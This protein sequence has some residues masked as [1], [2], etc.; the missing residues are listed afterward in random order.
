VKL[1]WKHTTPPV[2]ATVKD[3]TAQAE[4]LARI[5]GQDR[6]TDPRTNPAV[7]A[8]L[9]DLRDEQHRMLLEA[10]HGRAKRRHR[11]DDRHRSEAELTLQAILQAKQASSPA[12]SV[13]ALHRGRTW[14]MGG[15]LAAS[16]ALSVGSAFGVGH[17]ADELGAPKVTGWVAEVGMVGLSTIVI[18]YLAHLFR[19]GWV[20]PALHRFLLGFL[21]I[22]P[23]LASVVAN[24]FGAGPVGVACSVGAALFGVFSHIVSDNSAG[25]LRKKAA[26]VGRED[27]RALRATALGDDLF[28]V[29][30]PLSTG[31]HEPSD[32]SDGGHKDRSGSVP[33][34][35]LVGEHKPVATVEPTPVP[36]VVPTSEHKASDHPAPVATGEHKPEP[37]PKPT[38]DVP[39]PGPMATATAVTTAEV[40]KPAPAKRR[41]RDQIRAELEK[42]LKE[43]Y[44]NGGGEPEVKPLAEAI[45]A[46]RRIV[47][48]LLAEMNVRPIRKA[49][50]Q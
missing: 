6:L 8:L 25:A 47:R 12:R 50:N 16:V 44:D 23:L 14:F 7:R 11:V 38:A 15:S 3:Q 1:M 48:E 30:T 22:G 46:N 37:T 4:D 34:P 31:G 40:P 13:L 28:A 35:T 19:H 49:A 21:A 9:D 5:P 18:L 36:T 29:P 24:A 32:H 43:H 10:E 2:V 33:M 45:N 27:E 41:T 42:A 17:L 39:T 26:E 20:P